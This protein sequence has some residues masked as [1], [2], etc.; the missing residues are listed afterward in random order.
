MKAV[1]LAGGD[2]TR[3]YPL[4]AVTN[5]HLLPL[6]N[7]PVI[8]YAV[9]KLTDAG[10]D[11]I[12]VVSS[13]RH[14]EH[15]VSLLGSGEQ[16][17]KDNHKSNIQIVYG[18]QD[19]PQ[20]IAHA[21]SI[22][23][24]FIDDEEC[25]LWLGDGIVEDDISGYIKS[26]KGGACVFLKKVKDPGRF[27]VATVGKDNTVKEII[28]K[29]KNPKSDLAVI[30]VYI[31]DNTVFKKM[32]GQEASKRGEFEITHVNNKY[33]EEGTL[34]A[35]TLK[36][37]WFDIGTFESLHEAGIYMRKKHHGRKK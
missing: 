17:R 37:S 7:K 12:M 32:K 18:I 20:G 23:K 35:V 11:K 33:I 1:I 19:K 13:P 27:G 34:R 36:K 29:P 28:E 30:G 31:Y 5:K 14:I 10:I 4:T 21:L 3:L 22:A 15:F 2:G 25:I 9:E 24:D 8:Y 6:Y 16:F 26:F